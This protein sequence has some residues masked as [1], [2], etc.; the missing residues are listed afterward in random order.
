MRVLV[1]G[2]AGFLGRQVAA[3]LDAA[4]HDVIGFDRR[5]SPTVADSIIGDLTDAAAVTSAV[6]T[7]DAVAHL[8]GIGDVDLASQ[9]PDLAV[10]ANVAGSAN[11]GAAA[12]LAGCRVAYASTWEVYG[13]VQRTPVD[14]DHP[15]MP[16]H[17]YAVSKHLGEQ[18]LRCL[19]DAGGLSLHVLRLG[20]AYG[21]GMRP[22]AVMQRFAAAA[23]DGGIINIHGDGSQWRQFTHTVDIARAFALALESPLDHLIANVVAEEAVTIAELAGLV[24]ERWSASVSFGPPREGDPP[25]AIVS[26]A[27]AAKDLNWRATVPFADGLSALLDEFR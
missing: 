20:T 24:A 3:F 5:P 15:C 12:L 17:A 27:R 1:T 13:K 9:R 25:A 11:I 21:P 14:E 22:N 8:G 4:G 19:C 2:S 10:A 23:R 6:A 7:V 16:E 26:S 18:A